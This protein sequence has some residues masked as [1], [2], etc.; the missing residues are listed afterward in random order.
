MTAGPRRRRLPRT[1]CLLSLA[2][3]LACGGKT[4]EERLA[5]ERAL[6]EAR[7]DSDAPYRPLTEAEKIEQLLHA[8][9]DSGFEV[10]KGRRTFRGQDAEQHFRRR[11]RRMGR[12]VRTA[13]DF[14][15]KTANAGDIGRAR[16]I[17]VT[18][19]GDMF[20]KEWLAE[21]LLELER[22]PDPMFDVLPGTTPEREPDAPPPEPEGPAATVA[23]LIERVEHC[24]RRFWVPNKDGGETAY[25]ADEFAGLLERKGFWLA[26]DLEELGPWI[27]AVGT[28]TFMG[29][30]PYRVELADE[31]RVPVAPWLHALAEGRDYEPPPLETGTDTGEEETS[32]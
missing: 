14:V 6:Q 7:R 11:L 26:E 24:D 21:R 23:E 12:R 13:E 30:S 27:D 31:R 16:Y 29:R 1:A 15:Y 17:I 10:V 5:E 28:S 19:D 25:A 9:R 8:I 20:L 32:P 3:A 4:L 18:D 2:L 22:P